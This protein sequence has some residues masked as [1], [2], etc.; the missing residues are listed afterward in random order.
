MNLYIVKHPKL[1]YLAG[2]RTNGHYYTPDIQMSRKFNRKC[3]ASNAKVQI[4][5]EKWALDE[6]EVIS[7]QL[8][9]C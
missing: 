7:I 1:G 8:T 2:N 6:S 3:D 5:W 9:I 4:E